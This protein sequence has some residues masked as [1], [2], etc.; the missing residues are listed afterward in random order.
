MTIARDGTGATRTQ[1]NSANPGTM[2]ITFTTAN[3]RFLVIAWA[4]ANVTTAACAI[5]TITDSGSGSWTTVSVEV[6]DP[7]TPVGYRTGISY[8]ENRASIT[9]VTLSFGSGS[10]YGWFKL[11]QFTGVKTSSSQDGAAVTASAA[12]P[13]SS[14]ASG[15]LSTTDP[16]CLIVGV[17]QMDDGGTGVWNTTL[18]SWTAL[19]TEPDL[20]NTGAQAAYQIASGNTGPFSITWVMTNAFFE[21]SSVLAAFAP[22]GS[23]FTPRLSLMGMG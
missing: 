2:V 10:H 14:I 4:V 16:N 3:D 9:D 5:P 12:R 17:S 13:Q 23:S 6:I 19:M 20:G 8:S 1:I 18:G 22:A 11:D 7:G 15:N 21:A